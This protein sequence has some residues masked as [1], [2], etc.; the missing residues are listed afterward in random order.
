MSTPLV[1]KEA[2]RHQPAVVGLGSH[3]CRHE[4]CRG[5]KEATSRAGCRM[6]CLV[7]IV[8]SGGMVASTL[9]ARR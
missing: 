1:A 3:R 6:G 8:N 7:R 5:G 9:G 2:M 4:Q